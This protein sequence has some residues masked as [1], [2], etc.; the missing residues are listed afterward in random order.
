LTGGP[1]YAVPLGRFD[2]L[3]PAARQHVVESIPSPTSQASGL[4]EAFASRGIGQP[5][6]LVALSGAHTIGR[7]HCNNFM[8]RASRREGPFSV[9]VEVLNACATIANWVQLLDVGTPDVLDNQYYRNLM[10]GQGVFTS[11]MALVRD[12]RTGPHRPAVRAEPVR[13]LRRRVH[14]GHG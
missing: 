1:L 4:L 2:S 6:E 9:P 7:A 14:P 8:D 13:L 11:D 10:N 12:F 5:V 3:A